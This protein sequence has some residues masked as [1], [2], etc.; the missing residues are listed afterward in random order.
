MKKLSNIIKAIVSHPLN[1]DNKIK[2]IIRFIKWQIGSR[3]LGGKI[4]VNWVDN[5][6]FIT[7]KSDTGLTG[8]LYCGFIEYEE[9]SFLLHFL[10]SSD[11]FYD[12]GAN[13]GSYTILASAVKGCKSYSFEPLG[14]TFQSLLDQIKINR[15]ENIVNANNCG[16]G[17]K[18]DNLEFTTNLNTKN[19]VN[20]DPNNKNVIK[21]PVIALDDNFVPTQNSAV[22]IDVEGFEKFVLLGGRKFFKNEKISALIVETNES[23]NLYGSSDDEINEIVS[24]YG[25]FPIKYCPITRL[26]TKTKTYSR[27]NTIYIKNMPNASKRCLEAEKFLVHTIGLEI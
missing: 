24:S 21:V 17:S 12:I 16:I 11:H 5:S 8:N 6:K 1:K 18:S 23:G 19:K 27:G 15:I 4:I 14:D 25:F 2:S 3:L 26:I 7:F 22:K 9:M 13:V 10:R 20:T